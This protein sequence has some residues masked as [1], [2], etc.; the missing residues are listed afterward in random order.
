MINVDEIKKIFG[1]VVFELRSQKRMTQEELAEYLSLTPHTITRIETGKTFV[2]AEVIAQLCNVFN[3]SPNVLF[4]QNPHLLHEE[5]KNYVE[6]II[7]LLPGFKTERLKEIYN[8]LNII[9]K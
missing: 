8:I 3:I 9:N 4:T 7:K 5:H 2:S 6:E 1:K